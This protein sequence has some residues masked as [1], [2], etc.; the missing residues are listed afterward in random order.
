M[1]TAID[2]VNDLIDD[3]VETMTDKVIEPVV[4]PQRQIFGTAEEQAIASRVANS[5]QEW[6]SIDPY[7]IEDYG[8]SADPF[9][10]PDPAKALQDNKEFQFRWIERRLD[11]MDEVKNRPVPF[12]W[13][14]VNL[15]QPVGNLFKD[16]VDPTTGAVHLL[17]QMLVFKPWWMWVKE[18]EF[19]RKNAA[20]KRD[21]T[22]LDG[23]EIGNVELLA[24]KRRAGTKSSRLEIKGSDIQFTSED[25]IDAINNK[26]DVEASNKEMDVE[27]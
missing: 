19:K 20:T 3:S 10:L 14:P 13:W 2:K 7:S 17:D 16:F 5:S 27:I 11:R 23:T 24:T 26:V 4:E 12:R 18:Q 15:M 21:I 6:A 1:D 25:D 8:L 22:A 9:K